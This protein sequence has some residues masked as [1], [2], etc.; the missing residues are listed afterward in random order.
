MITSCPLP[1]GQCVDTGATNIGSSGPAGMAIYP[2]SSTLFFVVD[3]NIVYA[4]TRV[5][6]QLSGCTDSGAS[7]L[8]HPGRSAGRLREGTIAIA[9]DVWLVIGRDH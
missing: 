7:G 3:T 1:S 5:N 6:G 2:P 8:A 9:R 4:C